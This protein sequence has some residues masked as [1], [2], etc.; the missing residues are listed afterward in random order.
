VLSAPQDLEDE[1]VALVA[2]LSQQRIDVLDGGRLERLE[3]VAIVNIPD[4]ADD[5]V[6]PPD[7]LRQEI[8]HPA[9]GL[10]RHHR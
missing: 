9:R 3:P 5:I 7:V 2:V 10:R 4:D 8:A 6:A 1:L